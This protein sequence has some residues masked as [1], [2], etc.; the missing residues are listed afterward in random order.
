M[1]IIFLI[2]AIVLVVSLY[3]FYT[4]KSWQ[5]V[6]SSSRN[7]IVFDDRNKN[8]GAYQIR[9]DYDKNLIFILLGISVSVAIAFGA[10]FFFK[11]KPVQKFTPPS[12]EPQIISVLLP[13]IDVP[14]MIQK[15][16]ALPPSKPE[17]TK[18]FIPPVVTD[19]EK[20]TSISTQDELKDAK[21]S[22]VSNDDGKE[23]FNKN[24]DNTKGNGTEGGGTVINDENKIH[25]VTQEEAFFPGG[26]TAMLKF[27]SKNINYPEIA[28]IA[29]I[30]GKVTLNFVVGKNGEIENVTVAKGV[31]GCPEC[32][33][34]AI[35]VV[36]AMPK[37]KPAKN[38]GK[39][40]R[41]YFYLPVTFR[42]Q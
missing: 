31:P 41:S 13:P 17:R 3:D 23:T 32:D 40:V 20:N 18:E 16:Q 10:L 25:E 1:E 28:R 12:V 7:D 15:T 29:N 4:S 6:T 24:D 9:R 21:V 19:D 30:Q 27:L 26:R 22:T 37:W 33:K 39:A 5:Q 38:N 8:Y 14:D 2:T 42:L 35:R 11:E 34:E 36:K